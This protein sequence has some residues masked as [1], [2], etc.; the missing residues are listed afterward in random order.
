MRFQFSGYFEILRYMRWTAK[1]L[2]YRQ[3]GIRLLLAC[4]P[5]LI[6]GCASARRL[7][8]PLPVVS[9]VGSADF[10]Q[11]TGSLLGASFLPGNRVTTLNDGEEIFS[12]M[13][14]SIYR[15][16]RTITFETFVFHQGK[17]AREFVDALAA[18]ARAGVEVKVILDGLGALSAGQY[19]APLRAAGVQ[20]EIYHPI[21]APDFW[22]I[23]SRT[24]RKLLIVDGRIGFIGGVGIGDEWRGRPGGAV[25][26]R[27]L[28]YR[29]E[30]P[31]V[32]QMQAAFNSNWFK[33]HHDVILGAGYFPA[34]PAVGTAQAGVFY[35]APQHG[36]YAVGLMYHLAIAGARKSL[37]IENAYFVPD[38]ALATAL[39]AAARRGV[40]VQVIMAGRHI[41]FP[42]VR[43]ASRKRWPQ[44]RA[45][46]VELYEF[47]GTMLHSKLLVADGLFVSVGSANFDP[48]SLAINDEAN[49]NVLDLEFA[50]EQSRVFQRDLQRS[51][52]V[53]LNSFTANRIIEL[54]LRWL[55]AP[56]EDQL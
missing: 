39:C 10:A 19:H 25:Q 41:D 26:W 45:A 38:D 50:R 7:Q 48:R 43:L 20:L 9:A 53:N 32:A 28:H 4:L 6:C 36:R 23:N 34:L 35:S 29:V 33:L 13:L 31:V 47:R 56:F 30:G 44:L 49:L 52:P 5:L 16:Q 22:R 42:A 46:G 27:E 18:R 55:Q 8:K 12:A 24:H 51:R 17:V 2:V 54:P 1:C 11:A 21:W 40:K 15:A 37:L 14:R 3:H